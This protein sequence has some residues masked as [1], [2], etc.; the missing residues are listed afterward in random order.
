MSSLT[1]AHNRS[2]DGEKAGVRLEAADGKLLKRALMVSVGGHLLVLVLSWFDVFDSSAWKRDEWEIEAE[3]ATEI[4]VSRS[5]ESALPKAKVA[6]EAAVPSQVL[7]QLPM[8]YK[9][10]NKNPEPADAL[11]EEIKEPPPEAKPADKPADQPAPVIPTPDDDVTKVD[12]ADLLKRQAFEKL[13]EEKKFADTTTA[14]KSEALAR[15]KNEQAQDDVDSASTSMLSGIAKDKY[16]AVIAQAVMAS[17]QLPDAYNLKDSNLLA[18]IIISVDR[19][20]SL[21]AEVAKSS[22]DPVF[23]QLVVDILVNKVSPLPRPPIGLEGNYR[24]RVSP[25]GIK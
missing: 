1:Q 22:G 10:E 3:L 4:D 15:L 5:K 2:L 14:Q 13:R 17:Y 20:G 8:R 18:E 23:D 25:G 6:E 16:V 24:L 9:V 12:R 21:T 19:T 11:K 7:P